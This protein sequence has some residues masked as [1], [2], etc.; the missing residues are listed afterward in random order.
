[1]P[2]ILSRINFLYNQN[3]ITNT[4]YMDY[5][6]FSIGDQL[7]NVTLPNQDNKLINLDEYKGKSSIVLVLYPGDDTPG[8]TK[9]LCALRD[10]FAE[11]TAAGA[12]VFGVNH[13]SADS[14][15]KFKNKFTFPFDILVDEN[16]EFIK[17]F[18]PLKKFFKTEI[19]ERKVILV[20]KNG[21][22]RAILPG[23]PSDKEIIS[24]LKSFE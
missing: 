19:T 17:R 21:I 20:D 23:M 15:K 4:I 12:V 14:H 13:A 6:I 22:I 9:Q 16:R 1:M 8:C 7:G 5:P 11:I 3:I 2:D 18:G 10:D 24:Q